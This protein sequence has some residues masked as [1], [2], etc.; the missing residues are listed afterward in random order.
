VPVP[1]AC[2]PRVA[3]PLVLLLATLVAPPASL[4][5]P[6]VD[7]KWSLA[8]APPQVGD[9]VTL[10]GSSS[11]G[12]L[13]DPSGYRWDLGDGQLRQGKKITA[14]FA[15][16]G[17]RRITLTV[18]N[19]QGRTDTEA[20]D[21]TVVAAP[22]PPS[23]TPTPTPTATPSPAPTPAPAGTFYVDDAGSDANPGSQLAPWRTIQKAFNALQP[24]QTAL[25]GDGTY[26]ESVVTSRAG[27]PT[28][29]ITVKAAVGA[30]PI[31]KATTSH[32]LRVDAA[33]AYLVVQG[34][35]IR[36]YPGSSGGN[37]DLYGHDLSIVGNEI[38]ASG[39]QGIYTD[40]VSDR[41]A[42]SR[43]WIH[44]NGLG[45]THQSHGIYLQGDD[46]VVVD[47]VS[48]DQPYGFGI[49]VY[50]AGD[51]AR[52][53]HNTITHNAY[54][55]IVA[56]GAGGVSGV[57]IRNNVLAHNRYWGVARD[58]TCPTASVADH[59]VLW[60]NGSGPAQGGCTGLSYAGGNRTTDPLLA[61]AT[62]RNLHLR[63][64]SS[65]IDYGLASEAPAD[66]FDQQPRPQGAGP[67]AGAYEEG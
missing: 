12:K 66:D 38:T 18:S 53:V 22:S 56:G 45:R 29:P 67:D 30:R 58:S 32:A 4:A 8:P 35:V 16:A 11:T 17:T 1:H 65:A 33:G 9:V 24:G 43:N 51:R 7:A 39:D 41:I 31:W 21:V 10:D 14:S 25:V 44:H 36:D 40:E 54:S 42:V 52:V 63:T 47:N 37:V 19:A 20:R 62:A 49:Q 60:A 64:G 50:D 59:N 55:G 26:M 48:H 2:H 3:V 5:A 13:S 6:R 15:T 28:A 57:V 61:D 27:T 34:F 46:H 23:S